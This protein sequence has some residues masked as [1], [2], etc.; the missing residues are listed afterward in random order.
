MEAADVAFDLSIQ[1][2]EKIMD[3]L[4]KVGYGGELGYQNLKR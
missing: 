1:M 4:T 3:L 2:L